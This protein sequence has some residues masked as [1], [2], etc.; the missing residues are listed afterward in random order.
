MC[1]WR[2]KGNNCYKNYTILP[3]V[4]AAS[5]VLCSLVRRCESKLWIIT[6]C[7]HK[8]FKARRVIR[9][10][11]STKIVT[12]NI[13]D[14]R[15]E[16]RKLFCF[17]GRCVTSIAVGSFI[18]REMYAFCSPSILSSRFP[19]KTTKAITDGT[20]VKLYISICEYVNMCRTGS[21]GRTKNS[22]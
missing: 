6:N 12:S 1:K 3:G 9:F 20:T 19:C 7:A 2:G 5:F 11:L 14:S 18:Q 10:I 4:T 16:L 13:Y 8:G 21:T 15:V 22:T 17:Y